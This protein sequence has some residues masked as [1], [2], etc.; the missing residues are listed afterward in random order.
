MYRKSP[1]LE[2]NYLS[3][4]QHFECL[5]HNSQALLF[6]NPLSIKA[7]KNE[8]EIASPFQTTF[9]MMKN[10]QCSFSDFCSICKE[11][12][13]ETIPNMKCSHNSCTKCI[14][15]CDNCSEKYCKLCLTTKF[16][17]KGDFS[18][19]QECEETFEDLFS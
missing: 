1:Y 4:R 11:N 18:I 7:K 12:P 16:T 15:H 6:T 5:S 19:C 10:N 8:S 17:N 9:D 13:I 3:S 2:E 14:S